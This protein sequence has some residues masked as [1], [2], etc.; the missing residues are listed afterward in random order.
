MSIGRI[1]T[2]IAGKLDAGEEKNRNYR[3]YM[4]MGDQCKVEVCLPGIFPASL[5]E[6]SGCFSILRLD[7]FLA[8]VR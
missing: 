8:R 2:W 4:E 1:A 7:F 6:G 3:Y 5:F